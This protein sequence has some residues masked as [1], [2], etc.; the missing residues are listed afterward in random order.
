MS[1]LYRVHLLSIIFIIQQKVIPHVYRLL[2]YIVSNDYVF[3]WLQPDK[4]T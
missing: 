1:L 2:H 3:P 4:S